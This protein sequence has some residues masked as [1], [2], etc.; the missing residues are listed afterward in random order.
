MLGFERPIMGY[1]GDPVKEF[2][3][4]MKR[5]LIGIAVSLNQIYQSQRAILIR[6]ASTAIEYKLLLKSKPICP[7]STG[8]ITIKLPE[9][10]A[11]NAT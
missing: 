10:L 9:W 8:N 7:Q 1:P 11:S 3:V 4:M 2:L 5:S 6:P